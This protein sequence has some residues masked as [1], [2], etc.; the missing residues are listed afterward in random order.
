M[1]R[2]T[3]LDDVLSLNWMP[4][5]EQR[6]LNLLKLVYKAL[7]S[8]FWPG[9]LRLKVYNLHRNLRSTCGTQVEIPLIAN[10]FQDHASALFNKLPTNLRNTVDHNIF[11]REVKR[12]LLTKAKTT[13]SCQLSRFTSQF[14]S[15]ALRIFASFLFHYINILW[16]I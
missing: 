11:R 3:S 15:I 4:I 14:F 8:L 13:R 1:G 5:Q 7:H 9:Y 6:Q 12:F 10:T 16:L 2:Y